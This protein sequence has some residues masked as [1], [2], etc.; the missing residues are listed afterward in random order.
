M[1]KL[2]L[3][4]ARK[5]IG[6]IAVA[7]IGLA[8]LSGA[9]SAEEMKVTLSGDMEVPPV[10]TMASGTGTITVNPDMTV[11]GKITTSGLKGTVAHIHQGAMGKNGPPIIPLDKSGD[12]DW[13]VP[14]NSKLSEAEFK[15]FKAGDLY[16]NVHTAEH[17]SGEIRAQLKP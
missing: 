5:A 11:S 12:N 4:Y 15:A 2:H 16:V 13:V 10:K 6:V 7:A 14:K 8:G 3:S 17:K 9:A 1:N